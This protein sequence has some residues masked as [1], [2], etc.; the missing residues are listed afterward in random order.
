MR[1]TVLLSDPLTSIDQKNCLRFEVGG[2]VRQRGSET[3]GMVA[4]PN[5]LRN[6][7]RFQLDRCPLNPTA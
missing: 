5:P 7:S 6:L 3:L 2:E 4:S 1:L